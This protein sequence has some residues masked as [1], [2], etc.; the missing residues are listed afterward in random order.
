VHSWL[1]DRGW[2]QW[3]RIIL[4]PYALLP[5]VYL[6]LFTGSGDP[7]TPGWAYALYIAP[8][9]AAGFWLLIRPGVLGKRELGIAAAVVVWTV[10]WMYVI[11][12]NV[13]GA[14]P[15][16]TSVL[17]ALGVGI[18]EELTKALPILVIG[19]ILKGRGIKLDVRMWMFMGTIAGLTFGVVEQAN[20]V[21]TDASISAQALQQGASVG[22]ADVFLLLNF[23]E[24][25]F[26][27]GL[28]HAIWAGIAGFFMGIAINYRRRRIGII[29]LGLLVP[30]LL[31]AL[32][33]Y[34]LGSGVFSGNVSNWVWVLVQGVSVVLFLSYT[35][36]AHSIEEKVRESS[37]FRG[38]SMVVDIS[39][40]RA[41][42]NQGVPA[43][44]AQTAPVQ[45]P[46]QTPV[47]APAQGAAVQ[48][49]P[50]TPVQPQGT[51]AQGTPYQ[52]QQT[53]PPYQPQQ[54]P[55][56]QPPQQQGWP[57]Q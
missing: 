52:P 27:D 28:Q 29:A 5:L 41:Q 55:Q 2:R 34:V 42:W 11:T 7:T 57:Q 35:L 13:N 10:V 18:N 9:W 49:T 12:V 26:V 14:L 23:T 51:P 33:D 44:T 46:V 40:L 21:L 38:N 1:T 17:G 20:Y 16:L 22:Q 4:I 48:Q 25:V 24:R 37:V 31:H 19:L 30:A 54:Y 47:Q 15:Q 8:L 32:N 6:N 45:A 36:S 50:F 56:Q 3:T 53:Q 39:A 43:Q